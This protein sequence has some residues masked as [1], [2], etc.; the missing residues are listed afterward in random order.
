VS[1]IYNIPLSPGAQRFSVDLGDGDYRF[2]LIYRDADEAGWSMDIDGP[3]GIAIH[4]IPF[5]VGIDLLWQYRYFGVP[6]Q[7]FAHRTDDGPE[8][9]AYEDMG[10]AVQ[11]VYVVP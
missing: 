10:I 7:L 9:V 1:S 4:G 5:V 11:L 6:G 3:R 8:I 2:R